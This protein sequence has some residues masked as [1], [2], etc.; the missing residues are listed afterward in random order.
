[1][2]LSSEYLAVHVITGIMP[3]LCIGLHVDKLFV[4]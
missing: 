1:M 4:P 3:L 2:L